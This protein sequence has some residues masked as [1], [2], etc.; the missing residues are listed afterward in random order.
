[1]P[2]QPF[3]TVKQVAERLSVSEK[4]IR[5]A[6]ASGALTAHRYG[7]AIRISNDDLMAFERLRRGVGL[8]SY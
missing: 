7:R 1:M 6:I 5:R 2:E 3:L 4:H 8:S